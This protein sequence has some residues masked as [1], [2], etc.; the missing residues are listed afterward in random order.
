MNENLLTLKATMA[1]FFSAL[2][3]FLGW[4]MLLL[5]IWVALMALDYIS[6]SLAARKSGTWRSA[7]AREGILHKAGMLLIVLV[8]VITDYVILTVTQAIPYEMLRFDW[9]VVLFPMVTMWYILTEA[10]SIIENAMS[11]GAAVPQWLPR[12]LNATLHTIDTAAN[13]DET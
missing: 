11:L 13:P 4:R 9:P 1:A 2:A 7:A 8:S 6:G 10:G 12:L 5:L 3:A